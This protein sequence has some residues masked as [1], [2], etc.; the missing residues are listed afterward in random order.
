[1]VVQSGPSSLRFGRFELDRRTGELQRDGRRVRLQEQPCQV[2]LALLEHPGDIVTRD[3]LRRRL[4]GDETFVDFERG[5]NTAVKKARQALGDS[6]DTPRFIETLARRGYR[7]IATVEPVEPAGGIVEGNLDPPQPAG[8]Q[9]PQLPRWLAAAAILAILGTVGLATWRW[10]RASEGRSAVDA[11]ART[12]DLAVLPL[13]VLAGSPAESYIGVGIADAITTRLANT[14]QIALRPTSAVLPFQNAQSEPARVASSLRVQHLLLGTI[15]IIGEGYRVSL[16]LVR[17]DGVAV[18]G[19]SFD[20]PRS[21]LLQLQD[22]IA[23]QVV[24]ALRVELSPV[25]RERLHPRHTSNA[26]AHDRYL[27]GRSLL[28]NYT[29]AN[30]RDAVAFFEQALALDAEYA[31]ARASLATA[32]AWFSVRFAYEHEALAWGARAEQEARRALA[33][34]GGL[35]DAHFALASAAGTLHGG[36]AWHDALVHSAEALVLDPSLELAHVARMRAFYHLGLF[37]QAMEEA[38]LARSVNPTPSIELSR[39]EVASRLFA[40][41]FA[42][43]GRLA[44]ELLERTDAPAIRHYLGLAKYYTGDVAGARTLLA[45]ATRGGKPDARAQASLASVEAAAGLHTEARARIATIVAA[46]YMDHHVAYS[47]GAAF[48]QLGDSSKSLEWL[49]QAADTGFPSVPWY[50]RD[51]LLQPLREDVRFAGLI[52][53]LREAQNGQR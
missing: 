52:A 37:E 32:C 43:S 44:G 3:D 45:S 39:L 19:R 12:A 4:W 16:Q 30:M 24:G 6:A 41:D 28:V 25:E 50:A 29:E 27:R 31:L 5:L 48:A 26:A 36:F 9:T 53:R 10:L 33:Q 42:E 22:H 46:A 35:A 15:Q 21:G 18:W 8:N 2:L 51:P 7:F 23:D 13:R 11:P 49:Q 40:G 38:R 17:A 20:E 1:M 14:R 47:L 34:D